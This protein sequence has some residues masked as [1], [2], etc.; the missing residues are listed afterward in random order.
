MWFVWNT[1]QNI[2]YKIYLL[3]TNIKNIAILT[4]FHFCFR[5]SLVKSLL[6]DILKTED[7]VKVY[8][9]RLT[10]KETASLDPEEIQKYQKV[11]LV[12]IA[13]ARI[14]IYMIQYI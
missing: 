13:E 5:L 14:K 1:S 7:V 11:L 6:K 12:I 8:E 4:V 10:E 3:N 9:A 2:S